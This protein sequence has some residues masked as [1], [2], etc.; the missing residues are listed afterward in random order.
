MLK[1]TVYHKLVRKIN[2]IHVA[3]TSH[4]VKK[5]DYHRKIS[6]IIKKKT[7]NDH[8]NK[9]IATKEFNKLATEADTDHFVGK[10][11]SW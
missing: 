5:T 1:K 10:T 6:E 7:D 4:I 11:W 9:Y 8:S 3:D 2:A